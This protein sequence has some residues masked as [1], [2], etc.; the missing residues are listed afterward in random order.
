MI[1]ENSVHYAIASSFNS[2]VTNL[3]FAGFDKNG[4]LKGFFQEIEAHEGRGETEINFLA[5]EECKLTAQEIQSLNNNLQKLLRSKCGTKS[6]GILKCLDD[7]PDI[8]QM[9]EDISIFALKASHGE[10]D[11]AM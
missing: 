10:L 4:K 7:Y 3:G 2:N 6:Q 9:K 11:P 5:V 1:P 8:S